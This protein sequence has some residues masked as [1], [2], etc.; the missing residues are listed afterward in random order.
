[1]ENTEVTNV[2]PSGQR[3]KWVLPVCLGGLALMVGLFWNQSRQIDGLMKQVGALN[4]Q[5]AGMQQGLNAVRQDVDGRLAGFKTEV[6]TIKDEAKQVAVTTAK[7]S[8][9]AA[10][11]LAQKHADKLV[12]TLA[13][14]EAENKKKLAEE[15]NQEITSVKASTK[16]VDS[17]IS[18]VTT[19]VGNV[20]TEVVQT[21]NQLNQ[22]IADL[23]RATGDM[24]V[25]SGLIATNSS[26]LKAL[27]EL[28]ERNYFEFRLGKTGKP[29]RVGD[30]QL[31]VKRV[32]PKRARYTVELVADDRRIEKKDKTVN[33]P[34]QFYVSS[35]A[36]QPYEI[37]VFEIGKDT[38]IGYLST[39]K[40]QIARN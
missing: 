17:R 29:A 34:V 8:S 23:K 27:K 22:T 32:D 40:T 25:L 15:I 13:K 26:E 10:Q 20:K 21:R 35:K 5:V 24:G 33:E 19:D 16:Q 38:V 2:T 11:S 18:D 4:Q 31:Q 7:N 36:R 12:E 9:W 28:G 14:T 30:V 6:A 39:P 37:V 3:M 1:M